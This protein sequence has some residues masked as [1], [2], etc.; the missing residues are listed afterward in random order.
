MKDFFKVTA[1]D[2]VLE[3]ASGFS[4]VAT[5]TI[6]L[7]ETLGRVLATDIVSDV[8]LPEFMRSTMDG[9]AVRATST[10]KETP[11]I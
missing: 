9:Y 10:S 1:L 11:P 4:R 8:D 7:D 5:E 3:Y 2:K 6:P